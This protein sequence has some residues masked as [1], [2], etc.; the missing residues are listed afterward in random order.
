VLDRKMRCGP[1]WFALLSQPTYGIVATH[2]FNFGRPHAAC[3]SDVLISRL[4]VTHRVCCMMANQWGVGAKKLA[5]RNDRNAVHPRV[6]SA[7]TP[8]EEGT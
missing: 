7:A 5:P 2:L 8:F 4:P 1:L 6:F 3:G